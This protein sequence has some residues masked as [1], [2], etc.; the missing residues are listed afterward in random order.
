MTSISQRFEKIPHVFSIYFPPLSITNLY[1]ILDA[2]EIQPCFVSPNFSGS[3]SV[4]IRHRKIGRWIEIPL[5]AKP[6][7]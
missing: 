7:R 4:G 3:L 1:L 2:N 5:I 6:Q